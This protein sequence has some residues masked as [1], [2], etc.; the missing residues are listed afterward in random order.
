MHALPWTRRSTKSVPERTEEPTGGNQLRVN[1]ASCVCP[2]SYLVTDLK[3]RRS[4]EM[5]LVSRKHLTVF[6]STYRDVPWGVPACPQKSN[7]CLKQSLRVNMGKPDLL[8][9]YGAREMHI[10]TSSTSNRSMYPQYLQLL[11]I[12]LVTIKMRINSL[13]GK[14]VRCFK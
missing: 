8:C 5:Q 6:A 4:S 9:D 14:I 3:G 2:H 10:F 11:W 13:R 12:F 7:C 1:P